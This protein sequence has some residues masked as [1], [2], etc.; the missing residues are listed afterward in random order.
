MSNSVSYNELRDYIESLNDIDTKIDEY[1]QEA[2]EKTIAELEAEYSD[3]NYSVRK[4]QGNYIEIISQDLKEYAELNEKISDYVEDIKKEYQELEKIIKE[5]QTTLENASLSEKEIGRIRDEF[6]GK[7]IEKS[8]AINELKKNIESTRNQLEKLREK[9]DQEKKEFRFASITAISKDECQELFAN[10]SM[11]EIIEIVVSSKKATDLTTAR[12]AIKVLLGK[13]KDTS[14]LDNIQILLSINETVQQV[15]DAKPIKI[16]SE[17]YSNIIKVTITFEDGLVKVPGEGDKEKPAL[18]GPTDTEMRSEDTPINVEDQDN[19]DNWKI[20]K[21]DVSV[22]DEWKIKK[23]ETQKE[24]EEKTKRKRTS[25]ELFND[26]GRLSDKYDTISDEINILKRQIKE[27]KEKDPLLQKKLAKKLEEAEKQ[28]EKLK[29]KLLAAHEALE[30]EKEKLTRKQINKKHVGKEKERNLRLVDGKL[31][32]YEPYYPIGV[33]PPDNKEKEDVLDNESGEE[34]IEIDTEDKSIDDISELQ[35]DSQY[36]AIPAYAESAHENDEDD[37]IK[38]EIENQNENDNMTEEERELK[39]KITIFRDKD[40]DKVYVRK[41]TFTRFFGKEIDLEKV[42]INGALCCAITK[43]EENYLLDNQDNEISPYLINDVEVHLGKVKLLTP[44]RISENNNTFGNESFPR[45]P[46]EAESAHKNDGNGSNTEDNKENNLG[47]EV[48]PVPTGATGSSNTEEESNETG[49]NDEKNDDNDL[50]NE[51]R[52]V[53]MGATGSSNTEEESNKNNTNDD[54]QI[55]RLPAEAESAHEHDSD[56]EEDENEEKR[57]FKDKVTIFRDLDNNKHYIRKAAFTR[58]FGKEQGIEEV[59][60]DGALCYAITPKEEKYLLD[61]QD[62]EL[63]PYIVVYKDVHL[64]KKKPGVEEENVVIYKAVDDNGQLY[65]TKDVHDK[66]GLETEGEPIEI[67]GKQCY[68]VSPEKDKIINDK[69]KQSENPKI[70]VV[71]KP[72]HIKKKEQ[73]PKVETHYQEVIK[74]LTSE[75]DI[76]KKDGKRYRASNIKVAKS[77]KDELKAGNYLYN[78]LHIAPAVVKAGVNFFRKLTS[79]LFLSKRGRDVTKEMNARLNGE[80]ENEEFN[81]TDEDL[82]VLWQHYKGRNLRADMNNQINPI[83]ITKLREYGL[84]KVEALN[85]EIKQHYLAVIA[86]TDEIEDLKEELSKTPDPKKK[87]EL[88]RK[89]KE[90]YKFAANSVKIIEDRRK[91]ADDLLSNGVHGIEEDFKAVE[92]KMNYIGLRFSKQNHFDNELQERLADA[93]KRI[94]TAKAYNDDEGL[95]KAFIDYEKIYYEETEVKG[96]LA[97]K[98]STGKK[99]YQPVAELMDYRDDPFIRDLFTTIAAVSA[100]VSIANG[101]IT[102]L[103]KDQ[104]FQQ[105]VNNDINSTNAANKQYHNAVQ[106][107]VH[108]IQSQ[109]KAEI[110]GLQGQMNKDVRDALNTGE[111]GIMDK[112][113]WNYSGSYH[114]DDAILHTQAQNL[115]NSSQSQIQNV[116]SQLQSGTITE[117]QA[118]AMLAKAEAN[119]STTVNN[120]LQPLYSASKAYAQG[121]TFAYD[122]TLVPTEWFANHPNAF[123]DFGNALVAVNQSADALS[124]LSPSFMQTIGSLPSDLATTLAAGISSLALIKNVQSTMKNKTNG[125]NIDHRK[126]ELGEM[127]GDHVVN[128]GE[129]EETKG[130][131]K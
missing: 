109:R 116:V 117:T 29:E 79:K 123:V 71:Y 121:H 101:I 106:N 97:G 76:N 92:T 38:E 26:Y 81:L 2:F 50:D 34:S 33:T 65:A 3:D 80:S 44:T 85:N 99:W 113:G 31:E 118:I 56:N 40:N 98:R 4:N 91:K 60:I 55:P 67:L 88:Q 11:Q 130:R 96:S 36:V 77:F 30:E 53:P 110:E 35:T 54:N 69:A 37:E 120:A 129:E 103:Q 12:T 42:R 25:N 16:P 8:E 59:R 21:D 9:I 32:S 64:G 105:Q 104:Q 100:A 24:L 48:R 62:N 131:S 39:D 90:L 112:S 111:R 66:F 19:K 95:V 125:K 13:S 45:L 128:R 20:K 119:L 84:K 14:P 63:S 78:I 43:K 6:L 83:I 5:E 82:E 75:L 1:S 58:F 28:K 47:N 15:E 68:K 86:A 74:K 49:N 70:N 126:D 7:R 22:N 17:K 52:P 127:F 94:N 107:E 27:S 89:I 115:Y 61:N 93:G 122:A 57:G 18:K 124:L 108:N 41:S 73:Q 23:E 114:A 46:A 51:V 72:V 87:V 102:H 10:K